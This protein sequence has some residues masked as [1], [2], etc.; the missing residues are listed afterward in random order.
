MESKMQLVQNELPESIILNFQE[1]IF[2]E[3]M[4]LVN[5]RNNE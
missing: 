4:A 3:W 5:D 2:I 1:W